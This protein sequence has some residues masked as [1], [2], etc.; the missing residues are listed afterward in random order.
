MRPPDGVPGWKIF[1]APVV[2]YL[3][4][5]ARTQAATLM[6]QFNTH[7]S[8]NV[9]APVV[10]T[11]RDASLQQNECEHG[12]FGYTAWC[13]THLRMAQSHSAVSALQSKSKPSK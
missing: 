5:Y 12:E 6:S 2:L 1:P 10:A 8:S 9:D 13:C 3:V 7:A 4:Q 11:V